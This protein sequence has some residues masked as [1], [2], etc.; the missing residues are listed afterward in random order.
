MSIKRLG[1]VLAFSLIPTQFSVPTVGA[2]EEHC[3]SLYDGRRWCYAYEDGWQDRLVG[4]P[5]GF[6]PTFVI[7]SYYQNGVGPF[8]PNNTEYDFFAAL[9]LGNPEDPFCDCVFGMEDEFVLLGAIIGGE[10]IPG[11][12]DF[13]FQAG[14]SYGGSIGT[15]TRFVLWDDELNHYF[16]IDAPAVTAGPDAVDT[17]GYLASQPGWDPNGVCSVGLGDAVYHTVNIKNG[18]ENL[19]SDVNGF[20]GTD[21]SDASWLTPAMKVSAI[22]TRD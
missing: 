20:S 6:V 7:F 22:C 2:V 9:L 19:C 18:Y 10:E 14:C 16:Y 8:T 15:D 11:L 4:D 12:A 5:L 3:S 1:T 13:H 17:A 21:L